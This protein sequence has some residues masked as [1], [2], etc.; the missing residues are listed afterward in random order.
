MKSILKMGVWIVAVFLLVGVAG[1][2]QAQTEL[3]QL[4]R[5]PFFKPEL[6]TVG[7]FQEMVKQT[8]PD[9]EKGFSMAGSAELFDDFVVQV[10]QSNIETVDVP[11]G[12]RLQWM[13]YRK[14]QRVEVMKDVVWAGQD[15]FKAFRLVVD[16]DGNRNTFVVPLICGNVTLARTTAV[17]AAT[18]VAM[19]RPAPA[20]PPVGAAPVPAPVTTDSP[21]TDPVLKRGQLVADIGFLHQP[22]PANYLLFRVGYGYRFHENYSVLGMV[23]FAPV[24]SGDDDTDSVMADLTAYYHF[25]RMHF[26]GGLGFWDSSR[27]DRLDLIL[28]NTGYR[29]YGEAYQRNV[30]LFLEVRAA[31]DQL[32][33]LEKYIRYGGGVRFHF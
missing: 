4:G 9:L 17:P 26:G 11:V 20:V 3:K 7:D 22:D 32:D 5:S 28:L 15:S 31:V 12:E 16:Q 13:I 10:E 30:S 1:M 2:A 21:W 23:G 19:E 25:D 27:K 33:E 8:L 24:V 29:I 6:Q 14:A 18:P